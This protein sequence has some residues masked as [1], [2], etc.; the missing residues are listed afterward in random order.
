MQ[1]TDDSGW[2]HITKATNKQKQR[3]QRESARQQSS[4][5]YLLPTPI[6]KG[7]TLEDVSGQLDKY[8]KIWKCSSCF[9][10]LQAILEDHVLVSVDQTRISNC[11]CLGLGS[12]TGGHRTDTSLFQLATLISILEILGQH[13]LS[14]DEASAAV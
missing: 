11:V 4:N 8:M 3:H 6:P 13:A 14:S 1:L 2:T 9:N 7:L 5:D 12:F 10:D